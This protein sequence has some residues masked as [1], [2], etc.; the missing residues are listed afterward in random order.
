MGNMQT[1]HLTKSPPADSKGQQLDLWLAPAH[2]W[3]PVKLR[4]SEEDGEFIE[5]TIEKI[6]K[7]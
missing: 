5:Q 4:F 6:S 3:Y 1:V 2:E 7:K